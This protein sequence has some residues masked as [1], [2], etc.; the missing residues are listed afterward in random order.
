M[1][2]HWRTLPAR[3]REKIT[4][5]IQALKKFPGGGGTR[6]AV[7]HL[8]NDVKQWATSDPEMQVHRAKIRGTLEQCRFDVL[9]ALRAE[10]R[11]LM[12]RHAIEILEPQRW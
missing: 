3:W 12:V 7:Y 4:V 11:N 1:R 10:S 8:L 6:D 5:L 2:I 9:D